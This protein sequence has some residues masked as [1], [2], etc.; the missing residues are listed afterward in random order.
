MYKYST[1][2]QSLEGKSYS[3]KLVHLICY[4]FVICFYFFFL[5]FEIAW[6]IIGHVWLQGADCDSSLLEDIDVLGIA[7][8]WVYLG[9]LL[10]YLLFVTCLNCCDG[11]C[12]AG[13]FTGCLTCF[14]YL[15]CCCC[16]FGKAKFGKEHHK[17]EER[18]NR[19][20]DKVSGWMNKFLRISHQDRKQK[21]EVEM[22]NAHDIPNPPAQH[23]GN[24]PQPGYPQPGYNNAYPQAGYNPYPQPGYN[25]YQQPGYY[26]QQH[27]K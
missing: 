6:N 3:Q 17:K 10:L 25:N 1:P 16:C 4:D 22:K 13:C 5:G 26:P 2:Q 15:C 19:N 24:Y 21:G 14:Y 12:D 20:S 27:F 23:P 8:N 7:V 9:I 18:K 11:D